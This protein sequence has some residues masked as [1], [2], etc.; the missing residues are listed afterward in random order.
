M[1]K[2]L[3]LSTTLI[4]LYVVS[5]AQIKSKSVE[6]IFGQE[7][8]TSK[9]TTLS[10]IVGYDDNG[11]YAI[12]TTTKGPYGYGLVQSIV[13]QHYD[14]QMLLTKS[15]NLKMAGSKGEK[16]YEFIAQINNKLYIFSSFINKKSKQN[17]LYFQSINKKTLIPNKDLK[18][19]TTIKYA[20]R[21]T[22]KAGDFSVKLSRDSSKLLINYNLPFKAGQKEKFGFIV[23]NNSMEKLWEKKVSM[24]YIQELFFKEDF[25]IDNKGDVY[26]L[27]LKYQSKKNQRK[28]GGPKYKYQI[29]SYKNNGTEYKE[30]HV[31][32]EG[33]SLTEMK[34][35]ID[36]NQNILCAGFYSN[37][38]SFDI[39]G[40][41]YI[42][43]DGNTNEII[44]NNYKKFSADFLTQNMSESQ[45]E[46]A[47]KKLEKGK[48]VFLYD[49]YLDNITLKEDGG[50]MLI[51]EQYNV[52]ITRTSYQG[53][54]GSMST[55]TSYKYI[56]KD[57]I[58]INME[59]N[60]NVIW[61]KKIPKWQE[62][63]NDGGFF[64]SYSLSIVEDELLFIFNDNMK[65]IDKTKE[66]KIF[67][68]SKESMVVLVRLDALGNT[69][70][71]A[72]FSNK[73]IGILTR[74]LV[75]EQISNNET[76][77]FGQKKTIQKL[78]K[79]IFNHP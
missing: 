7:Q 72:L 63:S 27:G 30:Y 6:L 68:K 34:I 26:L 11:I 21:P 74:P 70:K 52:R 50:L 3:F 64:S 59:E 77:L 10:D 51:A 66:P 67:N 78:S 43:L 58:V 8:R 76:I 17:S 24:P 33:K 32:I 5:N 22:R 2:T 28:K 15:V 31:K 19:V 4:I 9:V 73:E 1:I 18:R 25:E 75:C 40:S 16:T 57:I 54:G 60:G 42:K 49:Y 46:K 45:A 53:A 20:G 69:K 62:T 48:D 47:K 55:R 13:L 14:K 61:A 23:Y 56:Y 12:K 41:Y 65:N 79:I 36:K 44:H 37:I 38:N 29:L 71:E 39:I 35:T